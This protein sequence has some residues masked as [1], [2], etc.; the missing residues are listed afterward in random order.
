[1]T[2]PSMYNTIKMLIHLPCN[3]TI[4]RL[5]E[6]S[7]IKHQSSARNQRNAKILYSVPNVKRA[8]NTVSC[9]A[10]SHSLWVPA[11]FDSAG[12]LR[13]A[14][15]VNYISIRPIISQRS[16]GVS[17]SHTDVKHIERRVVP[18]KKRRIPKLNPMDFIKKVINE[19][20]IYS[21]L[22]LEKSD[23]YRWSHKICIGAWLGI[24]PDWQTN[25]P[26]RPVRNPPNKRAP[27]CHK[28]V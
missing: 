26:I 21:V 13:H 20:Q 2:L 5:H 15:A 22:V 16:N 12:R 7:G 19:R 1:M 9:S 10:S 8:F 25:F 3:D 11:K 6:W 28:P 4:K 23:M 18:L 24:A 17:N 14:V 27:K